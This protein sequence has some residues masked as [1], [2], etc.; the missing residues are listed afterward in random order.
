M[1]SAN[2]IAPISMPMIAR[3]TRAYFAPVNRV[4][5][6][7]T[8]FDPAANAAWN[9]AAPAAPWID[10]GWIHGF[11]RSAESQIG[12]V[13]AGLPATVLLQTRQA[14][15]AIVSFR[16]A[17]WSKLSMALATSSQHMNLLN[18]ES[19]SPAIGSGAKAAPAVALQ[20]ASSSTVLYLASAG[21][22]VQPGGM[23]VVD[24]DYAMQTGFV[25]AAVSGGY[26][27]SASAVG[28]DP[29]Y[30]R[31]VSFNVGRVV[32][33]AS[34]GGLELATPLLAGAPTATMK[35]QQI[36]GFVD[37]EGGGFFQEWS[38]LFVVEGVQGDRLFLHY[39]R[40]QACQGS[41]EVTTPLTSSLAGKPVSTGHGK[42]VTLK[43]G[44]SKA[45]SMKAT[46]TTT[47]AGADNSLE[48]VEPSSK[49]R[50]LPVI[51]GNDGEQILCYRS[52]FPARATYI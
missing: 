18:P 26:V 20:A 39:P 51:D 3:R 43:P 8:L 28:S 45:V 5:G 21:A 10:L 12:E 7:P 46:N 19:S 24:N 33:I 42:A 35:L 31:R 15:G 13:D 14:L 40:L 49:F 4:T 16:F 2:S 25:G 48:M 37:R 34:D 22:L 6:T 52:Y 44:A 41:Q 50:A 29:D 23:I 1:S 9:C 17:T 30:I 11:T 32:G 47:N 38:A 36:V 27:Q